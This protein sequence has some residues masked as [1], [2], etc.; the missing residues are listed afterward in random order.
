MIIV[1]PLSD[2][3]A[4]IRDENPAGVVTLLGERHMIPPIKSLGDRHLRIQMD[5]ISEPLPGEVLP[6]HEHLE[7][8]LRFIDTW[9]NKD[10]PVIIHCWAGISR[11]TA[12]ALITQAHLHPDADAIEYALALRELAPHAKPNRRLIALADDVLDKKGQLIEAADAVRTDTT[13]FEG[14]RFKYPLHGSVKTGG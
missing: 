14:V 2:L 1:C 12:S 7:D 3:A 9:E 8:L 4:A 13:V 6:G 11:S 10:E 5:D